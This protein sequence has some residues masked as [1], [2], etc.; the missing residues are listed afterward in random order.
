MTKIAAIDALIKNVCD[1]INLGVTEFILVN[2]DIV[3]KRSKKALDAKKMFEDGWEMKVLPKWDDLI[4]EGQEDAILCRDT[5][6]GN[7]YI[8]TQWDDVNEEYISAEGTAVKDV[9]AVTEEEAKALVYT[10]T[11][12]SS[13]KK[14]KAKTVKAKNDLPKDDL[15]KEEKVMEKHSE[16]AEDPQAGPVVKPKRTVKKVVGKSQAQTQ[17]TGPIVKQ[18]EE[19]TDKDENYEICVRNGLNS[20]RY[21]EFV[22]HCRNTGIDLDNLVRDPEVLT[23][24]LIKFSNKDIEI[25]EPETESDGT[26]PNGPHDTQEVIESNMEILLDY[27]LEEEDFM[28]FYNYFGLNKY[29]LDEM[30]TKESDETLTDFVQE[31]YN[32]EE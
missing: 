25:P 16:D 15:P 6:T 12:L 21:P 11:K 28:G 17:D 22:E 31:F 2:G 19:S 13:E 24:V 20:D 4:K 7:M 23:S 5:S 18:K 3:N 9:V 10:G 29:T 14:A 26:G 8:I 32:S 27:G 30:T 1:S